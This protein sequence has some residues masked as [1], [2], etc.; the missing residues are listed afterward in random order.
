MSLRDDRDQCDYEALRFGP[1]FLDSWGRSPQIDVIEDFAKAVGR[2]FDRPLQ[3]RDL[4]A[5]NEPIGIPH[6]I[7]H[8]IG[9][10]FVMLA[11]IPGLVVAALIVL[12]N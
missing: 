3:Q 11:L 8:P 4:D 5:L 9:E 6:P 7:P 2:L 10:A 12:P 1:P